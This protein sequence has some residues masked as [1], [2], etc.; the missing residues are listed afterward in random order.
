MLR[1][2]RQLLG[3]DDRTVLEDVE[4][5]DDAGIVVAHV[6]PKSR[7]RRRCG[8]CGRR[9]PAY[10]HG[11]G[12]RRWRGLDLGTVKVLLEADA[13]RV[14]C[15]DHGVTVAAVPWARHGAR[16][17]RAFEDTAA[18]LVTQCSK[19][20]VTNLLRIGWRT[21][22][23]IIGRVMAEI[24]AQVDRLDGLTRIGI[25]EVSY[26]KGQNY[27]TVVVD[28]DTG[29]LVWVG[30]GRD[31]DTIH[32]FFDDLGDAR[33]AQITHISADGAEAIAT[34]ARLRAP[35]AVLCAD[36]FHV[37]SWATQCLDDVPRQVWNQARR[38]G[39][40]V[41]WGSHSGLRYNLSRGDARKIQ[42]SRWALWKAG[43]DLTDHQRAKLDWI[44]KTWPTLHRAYLLKEGLRFVFAIKGE[45][46]KQA[47]DRW[48]AWAQRS[49]I[50][51]FVALG[52]K[53][54]RHLP[55]IHAALDHGLS[56]GLIESTN[57]K[58]R[59]LTR[60]AFGFKNPHALIALAMLSLGGYRPSLPGR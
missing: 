44:A 43:D 25:D 14:S 10:D 48:L 54:K 11:E 1:I 34:V 42:H 30:I 22:G 13:P 12:R 2:W 18:W 16:H 56:N 40:M 52:Q 6:R 9:S 53:I 27:L 32:R 49:R 31:R 15:R 26:K 60:I 38:A 36:P 58:I 5:D 21:V 57:T 39:D 41:A 19:T 59:L 3:L 55:A 46:G 23:S 47:L 51:V 17:T 37:V 20:A 8:R 45:P 4:L 7:W 24:D 28:H 33:S 29:R 50:P 35:Q